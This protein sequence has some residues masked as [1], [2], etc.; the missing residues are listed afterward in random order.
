MRER[1]VPAA[2]SSTGCGEAAGDATAVDGTDASRAFCCGACGGGSDG[3]G[4]TSSDSEKTRMRALST[5]AVATT[6]LA[7]DV[8]D[9]E[10]AAEDADADDPAAKGGALS[11]NRHS[12][13]GTQ[14]KR[15]RIR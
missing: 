3:G 13:P 5:R 12:Y 14:C 11:S 9:R 15:A 4:G 10:E 8:E 7:E 6:S 1:T 2:A